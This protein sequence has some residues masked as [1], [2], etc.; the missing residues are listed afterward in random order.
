CTNP[1]NLG[2]NVIFPRLAADILQRSAE[3]YPVVT[4]VGP[5]QAGKTTLTRS[6]FPNMP[7][8]NLEDPDVLAYA[9]Y[10]PRGF[11]SQF[12]QGGIIDE[13]QNAPKLLSFIQVIVDEKKKNGLFILTGS[14]Q[15]ELG[16]AVSQ[17]L[18][19][20]TALITLLSLSISELAAEK[21]NLD[22]DDYLLRGFLPRV[23]AQNLEPRAAYRNYVKTYLERDVRKLTKVHDLLLFQKFLRLCAARVGSVFNQENLGNEVG[24]SATTI[25]HWLAIL[26]ASY[27]IFRIQPYFEN[28]GKRVIKSPKIYFFDVGLVSYLLD[29][30]TK[31]QMSRDP[32]RGNLV[33]NLIVLELI[34]ARL[35]RGLEPNLYFFRDNHGNEIDLIYKK[36]HELIPIEIKSAQSFDR[37]FIK[38]LIYFRELAGER[39]PTGYLVYSGDLSY[40]VDGFQL[41]N[42]RNV[43]SIIGGD[44]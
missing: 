24:V 20:R 9:T 29:I 2:V 36:A 37:S 4:L 17:S 6:V 7:Y 5:R 39:V 43:S 10:D 14:Q 28:F 33:E 3:Q 22:L 40:Q 30:E 25:N 16:E 32:L 11:L 1:N 26:E 18:A 12:P 31:T 19:G 21:I 23:Y 27:L 38:K 35:N 34:K 42:Y 8:V 41:M 44:E 15:L 13:I